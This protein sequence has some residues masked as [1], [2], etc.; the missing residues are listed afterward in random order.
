MPE[1]EEIG[2]DAQGAD[3]LD[4]VLFGDPMDIPT[5]ARRRTAEDRAP[6][7]YDVAVMVAGVIE[8]SMESE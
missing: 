7:Q 2:G 3:P 4:V 6:P 1:R 8:S 5:E